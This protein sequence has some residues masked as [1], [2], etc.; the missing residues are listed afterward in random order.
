M[1]QLLL[2]L[3]ARARSGHASRAHLQG[4]E[5]PEADAPRVDVSL[6]S[7]LL[8]SAP[9]VSRVPVCDA[10]VLLQGASLGPAE[11]EP[12]LSKELLP[13]CSGY[14]LLHSWLPQLA[15]GQQA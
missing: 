7:V 14:A 10:A 9:S 12:Q 11:T 15:A 1:T 6:P 8:Q 13:K 2:E 4:D 5:R 3:H